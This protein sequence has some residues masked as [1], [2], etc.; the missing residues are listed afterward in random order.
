M[1]TTTQETTLKAYI[2]ATPAYSSFVAVQDWN[3][4]ATDLAL[5]YSPAFFVWKT[6]VNLDEIMQNGFDWTQVDNQTVGKARIWEWMF[7]NQN[8]TIDPSKANVRAGIDESWKGTAAMLAV[9]TSVY[10]HCKR[11]ANKLEKLFAIGAGTEASPS[12]LAIGDSGYVEGPIHWA[13]I[14]QAMTA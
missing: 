1:L 2:L 14:Q 11:A 3:S 5:D 6:S 9:R 8:R 7:N 13:E 4:I 10:G 12:T